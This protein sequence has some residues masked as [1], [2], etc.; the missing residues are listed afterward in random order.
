MNKSDYVKVGLPFTIGILKES[1]KSIVIF[2]NI[3]TMA[4]HLITKTEKRC[5]EAG[6]T[7]NILLLNG[8][9]NKHEKFW[10]IRFF[11]DLSISSSNFYLIVLFRKLA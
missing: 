8:S 5:D 9:L 3:R 2:V 11:C 6:L 4:M 1:K 7:N 10:R